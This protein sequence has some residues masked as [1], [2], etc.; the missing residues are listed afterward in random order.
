MPREQYDGDSDRHRQEAYSWGGLTAASR[1][2]ALW[3]LLLPFMLANLAFFMVPYSPTDRRG[4]DRTWWWR[5]LSEATQRVFALALTCLLVL[6]AVSVSMDLVGWQCARPGQESCDRISWLG[7]FYDGFLA[8]P[9]RRLAVTALVPL[10]AVLLL[11]WL[12]RSTWSACERRTPP[13]RTAYRAATPEPG[14]VPAEGRP[15]DRPHALEERKLWNGK[16][17]VSPAASAHVTAAWR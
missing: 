13:A 10:A 11:W 6:T 15:A 4:Q 17:P 9:S 14:A 1:L 8:Q 7:F 5:K 16:G 12:S 2:R 3:L